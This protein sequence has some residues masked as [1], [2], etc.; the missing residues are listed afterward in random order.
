MVDVPL[1]DPRFG[2][3]QRCPNYPVTHDTAMH[4]RLRRYGN[5]QA[6]RGKTFDAFRTHALGGSYTRNVIVSLEHAKKSGLAFAEAPT[7]FLVYEGKFG[8]GK[9]HL[10]AAI[11]N[12]RLETYGEQV[13]FITVPDLLDLLRTT[14]D[15]SVNVT[16]DDY[17]DR[18]RTIPLLVLDD[19]GVEKRSE[20]A[21][22]KV[23]QLLNHRLVERR[24]TVITTNSDIDD[25]DPR[26]S[27]RLLDRKVVNRVT[28]AAP[29]YR[30]NALSSDG[31]LGPINLHLY[32]DMRFD[33]F[34]TSSHL[35]SEA[36]NL[37]N[38][39]RLAQD[40]AA[41]PAGWLYIMGD[42]GTGK[43]HLAA[44]IACDSI[45]RGRDV[46]FLSVPDLLDQLRL[47][48]DPGANAR[49]DKQFQ[50]IVN[51]PVLILDDV[52]L[53]GA[54]PWAREKLFQIIDKRYLAR[55]PTVFTS[56]DTLEE[57]DQRLATRMADSRICTAFAIQARSYVYRIKTN[58]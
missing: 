15:P 13:I 49:F 7:G 52:S 27:S 3:F 33:T 34:D 35:R 12:Y 41:H 9:T 29:D 43:T 54:T 6:Y 10:A 32:K 4:K 36:E 47:A 11:A 25:L 44:A 55:R 20:W 17:F 51:S 45:E 14:F 16:L 42:Y 8:C 23:F 50:G 21:T 18:I 37:A 40:W 48:F 22:E 53:A 2:R 28:I 19:L 58:S 56:F 24:P 46:R 5:L 39:K 26:L 31:D 57:T 38:A 1:D 30:R